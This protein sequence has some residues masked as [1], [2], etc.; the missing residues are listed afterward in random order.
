MPDDTAD[1][2]AIKVET[3]SSFQAKTDSWGNVESKGWRRTQQATQHRTTALCHFHLCQGFEYVSLS[4]SASNDLIF[5]FFPF[6]FMDFGRG[7]GKL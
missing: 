4:I 5:L 2:H 1:G 7:D 6:N 3:K